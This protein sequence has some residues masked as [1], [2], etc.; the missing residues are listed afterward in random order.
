[1]AKT[2]LIPATGPLLKQVAINAFGSV[3][4]LSKALKITRSAIYQWPEE[5]A[6]PRASHVREAARRAGL[7]R[8]RKT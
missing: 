1:M 6:E 8:E 3:L 2:Q 5:V 4:E 7:I